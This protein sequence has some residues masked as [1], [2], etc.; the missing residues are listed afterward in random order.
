MLYFEFKKND[1]ITKTVKIIMLKINDQ[2]F[3]ILYILIE[4]HLKCLEHVVC[5]N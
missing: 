5:T 2:W 4:I 3:N 1:K